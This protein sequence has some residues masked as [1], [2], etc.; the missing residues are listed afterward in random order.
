MFVVVGVVA[1]VSGA[2]VVASDAVVVV[3][4]DVVL[5]D[6]ITIYI[7]FIGLWSVLVLVS[8]LQKQVVSSIIQDFVSDQSSEK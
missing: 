2:I 4:D 6:V 7:D 5:Y 1:V 8:V 3:V